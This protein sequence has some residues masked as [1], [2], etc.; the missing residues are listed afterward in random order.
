MVLQE[1]GRII[2]IR[3]VQVFIVN[4]Q[5]L[6]NSTLSKDQKKAFLKRTGPRKFNSVGLD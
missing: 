4:K 2:I 5:K 1:Y 6:N 3:E